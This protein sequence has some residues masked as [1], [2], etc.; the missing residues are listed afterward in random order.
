MWRFHVDHGKRLGVIRMRGLLFFVSN[1]E[2]GAFWRISVAS[3]TM[4]GGVEGKG[5]GEGTKRMDGVA[6]T[7]ADQRLRHVYR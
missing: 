5:R 3:V 4:D 1:H 2:G 7:P 6:V